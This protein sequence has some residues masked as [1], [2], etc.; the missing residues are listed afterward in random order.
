MQK[1]HILSELMIFFRVEDVDAS[2]TLHQSRFRM[3]WVLDGFGI[4]DGMD[5]VLG[6]MASFPL[7]VTSHG[8][9]EQTASDSRSEKHLLCCTAGVNG[10]FED[11]EF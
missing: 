6:E 8:F 5:C 7:T 11:C 9:P 1:K 10:D 3:Y 4:E 2:V